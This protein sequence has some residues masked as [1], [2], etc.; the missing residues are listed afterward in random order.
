MNTYDILLNRIRILE[1]NLA[2]NVAFQN[3]EI[4][5]LR[6][7]IQT[8]TSIKEPMTSLITFSK[9]FGDRTYAYAAIRTEAGWS[10]TI[11]AGLTSMPWKRVLDFIGEANWPTIKEIV[12]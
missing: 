11:Q 6:D 10:V 7:A 5:E 3:K 9:T 12:S 1:K 8:A 2:A 4:A